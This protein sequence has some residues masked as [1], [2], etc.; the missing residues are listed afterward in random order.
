MRKKRKKSLL[1]RL[2]DSFLTP[3]SKLRLGALLMLLVFTFQTAVLPAE[4]RPQTVEEFAETSVMVVNMAETG[5]GSGT[6][7]ESHQD[8]SVIL[9]NRHVCNVIKNG[10]FIISEKSKYL[11]TG[12][13]LYRK[14]DLCQVRVNANLG[15]NVKVAESAPK[16]YSKAYISGHPS[17]Y[18]F[19]LTEGH[20]SGSMDIKIAIESKKCAKEDYK[21]PK[22]ALP[23]LFEGE[24]PVYEDLEA[25]LVTATI[26]PGSS[27]SGVFNSYGELSGV[28]F[29]SNNR[30]LAYALIVPH[31]Y[32]KDFVELAKSMDWTIPNP[33]SRSDSDSSDRQESLEACVTMGRDEERT[34]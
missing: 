24:Y 28:A 7:L 27:G 12:Y 34:F 20:F 2:K 26:S 11:I 10:G 31:Q 16:K 4:L 14:H 8:H 21:D 5:G 29:A 30:L 3:G 13:K 17:L 15:V 9:T 1:Y 18:P 33:F 19:V 22:K 25:Q 6:I 23:C 32:V